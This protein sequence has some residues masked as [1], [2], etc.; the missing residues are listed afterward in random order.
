MGA[1]A[2]CVMNQYAKLQ[3]TFAN[4]GGYAYKSEMYGILNSMAFGSEYYDKKIS[5]L[6]GGERTRLIIC[7]HLRFPQGSFFLRKSRVVAV[8]APKLMVRHLKDP[9]GHLVQKI[10]WMSR[11]TIW[12]SV[13]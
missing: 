7:T 9:V 3:D 11:P 1:S 6:S 2:G 13:L 10:P 8:V 12:I 5:T 4:E